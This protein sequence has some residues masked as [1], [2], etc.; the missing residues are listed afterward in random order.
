MLW[1]MTDSVRDLYDKLPY[2]ALSHP[3]GHPGLMAATARLS[4]MPHATAPHDC[5]TLDIGCA[6][7][8][9]LLALA[10]QF[11]TSEF[12]GIDLSRDAIRRAREAA[13]AVG[14]KNVRFE[15]ADL[16]DW[17]DE[18]EPFDYLVAHGMLSWLDDSH[19]SQLLDLC[20]GLLGEHGVAYFSYSTMPGGALRREAAEHVKALGQLGDDLDERLSRLAAAAAMN[21]T[22]YGQHLAAIFE[23]FRRKGPEILV[24]DELGPVHDPL[25]FSQVVRWTE[26]RG[27]RYLGESSL[28]ANLPPELD[29]AALEK[30]RALES[31]PIS[32]QQTLDLLTGRT[33]RTSLFCRDDALSGQPIT[34]AETLH[35]HARLVI[36]PLPGKAI[37]GEIVGSLH[38]ELAAAYPHTRPVADLIESCTRRLGRDW[39]PE[40]GIK[41]IADWLFLAARLGWIELRADPIQF[42]THPPTRPRLSLLNRHFARSGEALVDG[43]HRSFRLPASHAAVAARMDG[44]HTADDL[45]KLA[46][47]ESPEL[48]F[49]PWLAH[50]ASRGMFG[51]RDAAADITSSGTS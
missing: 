5:R 25:Y 42:P 27:L 24:F 48:D 34:S 41:T 15:V 8:H 43:F 39:E 10:A 2:P 36:H 31:D 23:D 13:E 22:P 17:R 45:E 37:H 29:P 32:Y 7:G 11:P 38:A 49:R 20:A 47:T 6:S 14:L 12:V 9:H 40:R 1:R 51:T 46:A 30:L 4:G 44:N 3:A 35:L 21:A 16:S 26:S 33:H 28:A 18:S 19:K 50:L